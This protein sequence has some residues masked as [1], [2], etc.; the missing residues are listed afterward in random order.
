ML[1]NREEK[2]ASLSKIVQPKQVI[3]YAEEDDHEPFTEWLMTLRDIQGRQH[4]LVRIGRLE[5]AIMGLLLRSAT[6]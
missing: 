4:I 5:K 6:V 2:V 3:I 1:I